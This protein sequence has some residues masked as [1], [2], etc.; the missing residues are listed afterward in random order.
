MGGALL[1]Y[2]LVPHVRARVLKFVDPGAAGGGI[3]DTFQVDTAL[4]CFLS[5][6]WFGKGPGEGTVKRINLPKRPDGK[7]T[8]VM[9][10]HQ[11]TREV[12]KN[13]SV[14]AIKSEGLLGD[15]Y[16]EISFGSPEAQKLKNGDTIASAPPAPRPVGRGAATDA[17]VRARPTRTARRKK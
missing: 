5:G 7:V 14:A 6:G 13:D 4:D 16:V 10:M 1:A 3:A 15:K 2:K 17:G 12:L 9:D 11:A 8:V